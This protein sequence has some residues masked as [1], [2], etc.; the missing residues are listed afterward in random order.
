MTRTHADEF[1][2][3]ACAAPTAHKQRKKKRMKKHKKKGKTHVPIR[4]ER[5]IDHLDPT[6][7]THA[8]DQAAIKAARQ[9]AQAEKAERIDYSLFEQL[10]FPS[11]GGGLLFDSAGHELSSAQHKQLLLETSEDRSYYIS[12]ST[13]KDGRSRSRNRT[14]TPLHALA[15][16][17]RADQ[18]AGLAALEK[19]P[20]LRHLIKPFL[21]QA[22]KVV[23]AEFTAATGLEVLA[24]QVHPEEGMLHLHL[25]YSSVSADHQLL[26]KRGHRGRHGLRLLGP[27]HGGTLRLVAAGFIPASEGS[28]ALHDL[29]DR[30]RE[31][32]GE[33][34]IDWRLSL[35]V[36][37]LVERF[38]ESH[39]L[40]AIFSAEAERYRAGLAARRA[41]RPEQLKAAK[42]K[43][44]SERDQLRAE[45][46]QLKAQLAQTNKHAPAFLPVISPATALPPL[47]SISLQRDVRDRGR[48][49]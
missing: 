31:L 25:T 34:P 22:F 47:P 38:I 43:A 13:R 30:V 29:N 42:M 35:V 17:M 7:A 19:H 11:L 39:G 33:Q 9:R 8:A 49:R 45:V 18:A 27:S 12:E 46:A 44:E 1:T 10:K 40:Q 15:I 16:L 20:E 28:L 5:T 32:G 26:W 2:H 24:G 41:E 14:T 3:N 21:W 6:S 37:G 48:S 4:R 36:E 23:A